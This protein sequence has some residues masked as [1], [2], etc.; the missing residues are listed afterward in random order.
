MRKFIVEQFRIEIIIEILFRQNNL[1]IRQ[2]ISNNARR[3][4]HARHL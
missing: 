4:R 1:G 2:T 3:S